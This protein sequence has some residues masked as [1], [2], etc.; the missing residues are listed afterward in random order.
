MTKEE[1]TKF[2]KNIESVCKA[3]NV[4][5]TVTHMRKPDLKSIKMELSIKVDPATT[6]RGG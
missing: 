5:Y 1:A 6:E 3:F 4:W 2:Q